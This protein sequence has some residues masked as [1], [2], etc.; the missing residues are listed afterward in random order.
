MIDQAYM[1]RYWDGRPYYSLNAWLKSVFGTKVYKLSLDAGMTC[2]NRDGT[3]GTGGCIFC[4]EGGSG[5]F[6]TGSRS[7]AGTADAAADGRGLAG[8]ADAAAGSRGLAG[9]ADTAAGS[10]WAG[11]NES[12]KDGREIW[13]P[14]SI[15]DQIEA[16]KQLVLGKMRSKDG[17]YIAYFQSFTNT[18]APVSRLRKIFF[19]AASHPQIAALSVATRPD[20]LEP[21]K[22]QLLS[23]LNKRKP[24]WVELGLQ[25]IH[26]DTAAWIR[27]GYPLSSFE[28]ALV[29][30]KAAGLTVIVH[31]ILGFP[32]ESPAQML[33]S[34]DYIA[35]HSPAVDGIKLQMLHVLKGTDLAGIYEKDPF[36]LFSMDEYVDLAITCLEHLPPSM[37]IHR[38]TGDGPKKLL[39]A[40]GWSA[41]KKRVLN[42]FT[43]RFRE[44]GAWQGKQRFI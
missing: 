37:V 22:I 40:P 39:L 21:E 20:C 3:A 7:L 41:D 13:T 35:D 15:W 26:P 2:P 29:R 43:R 33:Q 6:A 23:E 10:S 19:E 31:L 12:A 30:L 42:A 28:D 32:T 9:T 17:P 11:M 5:E 1:D 36:P 14:M 8:T 18:Y 27:R 25:T 24:V 38:L 16:A 44:R 34:V 4:S